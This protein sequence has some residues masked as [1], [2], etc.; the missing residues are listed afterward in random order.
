MRERVSFLDLEG[1][2]AKLGLVDKVEVCYVDNPKSKLQRGYYPREVAY[3]DNINTGSEESH[4]PLRLE[5]A[6]APCLV[7]I[8]QKF[9]VMKGYRELDREE[10]EMVELEHGA[11]AIVTASQEVRTE[12]KNESKIIG[13]PQEGIG[14]ID[15]THYHLG[16]CT[17]V[18]SGEENLE[19]VRSVCS[20][21]FFKERVEV[22]QQGQ[23]FLP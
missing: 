11:N 2:K 1:H 23:L 3:Q 14:S 5:E 7:V 20:I 4:S 21:S 12:L 10:L 8:D 17:S 18:T 19:R 13:L 16:P 22:P 6:Y 15:F 9:L